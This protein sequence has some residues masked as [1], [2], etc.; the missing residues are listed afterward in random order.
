[1]V[2]LLLKSSANLQ[3]VGYN[4]KS[5]LHEAVPINLDAYLEGNYVLSSCFSNK[6]STLRQKI[7]RAVQDF[8]LLVL[9]VSLTL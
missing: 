6:G 8:T 5:I 7:M 2:E 4:G 9:H 3:A 1:M